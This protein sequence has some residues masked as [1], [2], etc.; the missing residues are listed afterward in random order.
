MMK[1]VDRKGQTCNHTNKHEN[2]IDPKRCS[3]LS[4]YRTGRTL[5]CLQ[6]ADIV[7]PSYR[8]H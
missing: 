2:E 4:E 7:S 8:K 1:I 3:H 6:D 5:L